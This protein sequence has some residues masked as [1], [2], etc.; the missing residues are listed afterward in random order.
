M[1]RAARCCVFTS[2]GEISV[3]V[4]G[5]GSDSDLEKVCGVLERGDL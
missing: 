4:D 2:V 3:D 1:R 5:D